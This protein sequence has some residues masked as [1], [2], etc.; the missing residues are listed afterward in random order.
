MTNK[1]VVLINSLV[2]KIKKILLYEISCTKSQLP[3][4]PLTRGQPSPDPRSLC[5]LSS[6]E[7]VDPPQTKFLGTPMV[8]HISQLYSDEV[9]LRSGALHWCCGQLHCVVRQ[10]TAR[11]SE[12]HTFCVVCTEGTHNNRQNVKICIRNLDTKKER[13]KTIENF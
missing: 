2:P 5:P 3:P 11:V 10:L 9:I 6:T 8:F 7:F 4:E 13:E 1:L 12:K